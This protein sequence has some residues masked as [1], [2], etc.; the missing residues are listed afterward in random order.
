MA[1]VCSSEERSYPL[2]PLGVA[3]G[4]YQAVLR[5][6]AEHESVVLRK[7]RRVLLAPSHIFRVSRP[8]L[9]ADILGAN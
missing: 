9:R 7:S 3:S 2:I 8:P 1:F 5:P 6:N 4:T